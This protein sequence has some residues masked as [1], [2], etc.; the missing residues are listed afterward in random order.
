[1]A[2]ISDAKT[3]LARCGLAITVMP[4]GKDLPLK[5]AG[6]LL[7]YVRGKD[8]GRPLSKRMMEVY[9]RINNALA[10]LAKKD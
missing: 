6:K 1:M 10:L 7:A 4:R 3:I 8:N 2:R 9:Q 5:D